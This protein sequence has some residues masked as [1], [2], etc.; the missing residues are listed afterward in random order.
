MSNSFIISGR[1]TIRMAP[2]TD[3]MAIG[4]WASMESVMEE[5]IVFP[6]AMSVLTPSKTDTAGA[7]KEIIVRPTAAVSSAYVESESC[8]LGTSYGMNCMSGW[9]NST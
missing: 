4:K 5:K 9:N 3:A 6:P 8:K 7:F 2:I 1:Q